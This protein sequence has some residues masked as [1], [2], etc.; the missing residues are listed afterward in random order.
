M[1]LSVEIGLD[2]SGSRLQSWELK[3][4]STE[5]LD[6]E[7]EPKMIERDVNRENNTKKTSKVSIIFTPS[8]KRGDVEFGTTILDAARQLNVDS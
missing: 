3:E 8:G 6:A 1:T 2:A 5:D 7:K 4:I